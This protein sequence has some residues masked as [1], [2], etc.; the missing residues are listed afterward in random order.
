[1]VMEWQRFGD[2]H[3]AACTCRGSTNQRTRPKADRGIPR[4]VCVLEGHRY[5]L[6]IQ[7]SRGT[8]GLFPLLLER[9]H[10]NH[11]LAV[12]GLVQVR[13]VCWAG[14]DDSDDGVRAWTLLEE[15]G[16]MVRRRVDVVRPWVSVPCHK[17]GILPRPTFGCAGVHLWLV[18]NITIVRTAIPVCREDSA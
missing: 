9:E 17:F 5:V 12:P 2:A 15:M 11:P 4:P 18:L 7:Q 10:R 13:P 16:Q 14:G 3:P 8:F 6:D 1:M